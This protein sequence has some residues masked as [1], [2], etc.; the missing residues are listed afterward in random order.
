MIVLTSVVL[1]FGMAFAVDSSASNKSVSLLCDTKRVPGD[2]A[3]QFSLVFN[4]A[5]RS[6]LLNGSAFEERA[7]TP[8]KINGKN[9]VKDAEIAGVSKEISVSLDR[10]TGK[11]A[12]MTLPIA[13]NGGDF[14]EH[15]KDQ[16][17][18]R[19]FD[20]LFIGSCEL[21]KPKF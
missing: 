15:Q 12:F 5:E 7:F 2:E 20:P 21:S 13:T 3:V 14:T 8:Y 11:F 10:V 9:T 16:I 17:T 4:E 18:S 6:L 19:K 1:F